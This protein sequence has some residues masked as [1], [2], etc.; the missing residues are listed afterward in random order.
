MKASYGHSAGRAMLVDW[1]VPRAIRADGGDSL[2][3]ARL[4]IATCLLLALFHLIFVA[5]DLFYADSAGAIGN[6]TGAA[7][8]VLNAFLLRMIRRPR[9]V[10]VIFTVQMF[11]VIGHL[12]YTSGGFTSPALWWAMT[13][14]LVATLF[15]GPGFGMACAVLTACSVGGLYWLHAVGHQFPPFAGSDD[16]QWVDLLSAA[17]AAMFIGF[18]AWQYEKSR[19]EALSVAQ[20]AL[21]HLT[22][23]MVSLQDARDEATE[24]ALAKSQFFAN[25]SHEI[26]TP[27]NGIIGMTQLLLDTRL[28]PEQ[29]NFSQAVRTSGDALLRIINDILDV[30]KI[31]AGRM[32]LEA[33]RFDLRGTVEDVLELSGEAAFAKGLELVSIIGSGVPELVIGD[34]GRLR[35]VLANLVSNAVKFT[36]SGEVV[37]RLSVVN[38][39]ADR[40]RVRF[41]IQD[42]GIGISDDAQAGLFEPFAQG[43]GSTT[44]RF[45]GTGLGLTICRQLVELMG[46]SIS[47]ESSSGEGSTFWFDV[48]FAMDESTKVHGWRVLPQLEGIR[49]LIVDANATSREQIE[50]FTA[51]WLMRSDHA[52]TSEEALALLRRATEAGDPYRVALIDANVSDTPGAELIARIRSD[53]GISTPPM[54]L[55]TPMKRG[56]ASSS[57]LLDVT[58]RRVMKPV[59]RKP[60]YRNIA[61]TLGLLDAPHDAAAPP[62]TAS[63]ARDRSA[64][65]PPRGPLVLLA[66]D[67][68]VNQQVALRMLEK[69]GYDV[70][71]VENGQEAVDR[72]MVTPYAAIVMD[73]HMPLLDGY[74]ATRTIRRQEGPVNRTPIVAM[75]A[76]AMRGDRERCIAAGMDDFV[77]KPIDPEQLAATLRRWTGHLSESSAELL[78]P[79]E[80]EELQGSP[81][82]A[83]GDGPVDLKILHGLS[84]LQRPGQ[85][86]FLVRMID[87][88]I[89]DAA[90][91]CGTMREAIADAD[92]DRL[93]A[94][95][96]SLKSSSSVLGAQQ[97]SDL[98]H[99]LEKLGRGGALR[100][101]EMA[102][103]ELEAEFAKVR[104][105]LHERRSPRA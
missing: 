43:D 69:L 64:D 50:Q 89:E 28:N 14:P 35:Q 93:A 99:Q 74:E 70:D 62:T 31:E 46:G 85:P 79:P 20:R 59:R 12:S 1:F 7:I 9:V 90:R 76:S 30:S 58:T 88:F 60:L 17:S 53:E 73:C 94:M 78:A 39:S 25:M 87:L 24:A 21:A 104:S 22:A 45:G 63:H 95:A 97:M 56:A 101:A 2:R 5:N 68:P 36:D 51:E 72:V 80:L 86:N 96:H 52:G 34:T 44:R 81:A 77:S 105:V 49:A 6:L 100:E 98:C 40:V 27:L 26:R 38:G 92:S 3:R 32:E 84:G 42:T 102:V 48:P 47:V 8:M 103:T 57:G 67:H 54:V 41:V 4:L 11:A 33:A 55:L 82:V 16:S 75:T 23:T 83:D 18:I 19:E 65:C 91:R 66:E 15:V 10:G 71:L 13:I 37:V 61:V 29:R